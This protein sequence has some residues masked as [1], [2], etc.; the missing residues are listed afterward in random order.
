MIVA[1]EYLS[2]SGL[3]ISC[4]GGTVVKEENHFPIKCNSLVVYNERPLNVLS[5]NNR[6]LSA[7]KGAQQLFEERRGFYESLAD[8][9]MHVDE[10]ETRE[11]F[12]EEALRKYDEITGS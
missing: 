9:T 7:S 10:M 8:V 3:V 2:K 6:P 12:L 5:M 11:A 4:G 1:K